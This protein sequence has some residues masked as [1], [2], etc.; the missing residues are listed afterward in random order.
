MYAPWALFSL[1]DK[2]KQCVPTE[3]KQT[4]EVC[5]GVSVCDE[6]SPDRVTWLWAGRVAVAA[7]SS[8]CTELCTCR[9]CL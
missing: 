8:C 6:S 4:V 3:I 7:M 1:L 5:I 2:K 9:W